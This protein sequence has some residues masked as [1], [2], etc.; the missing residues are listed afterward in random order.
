M[1]K[2]FLDS[3]WPYFVGAGVLVLV[4]I[5]T[6]FEIRT[7]PRPKAEAQEIDDFVPETNG[8]FEMKA[9]IEEHNHRARCVD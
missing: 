5:A 3:P 9:R 2:R 7:P 1:L 6:Q 8:F 4:A